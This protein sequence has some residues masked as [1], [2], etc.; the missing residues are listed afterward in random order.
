MLHVIFTMNEAM[1]VTRVGDAAAEKS[2]DRVAFVTTGEPHVIA[3]GYE[4]WLAGLTS[5]VSH[6]FFGGPDRIRTCDTWFRKP[7]LYPL[8]YGASQPLQT[9]GYHTKSVADYLCY[10]SRPAGQA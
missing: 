5:E 8:S 2:A 7:L 4:S 3:L 6:S 1:G 10:Q 9:S